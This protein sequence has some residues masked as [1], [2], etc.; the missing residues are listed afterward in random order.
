[1]SHT[2]LSVDGLSHAYAERRVITDI[3]FTAKLGDRIGLIGENGTGKSTLLRIL[4]GEQ[5]PDAGDVTLPGTVGLLRQE[6]PHPG[7]ATIADVLDDAQREQL[8]VL[9]RIERL[10]AEIARDPADEHAAD[11]YT[12]ALDTADR[13]GAWAAAARR[14]EVMSGLSLGRIAQAR[15]V[16]ELSGGQRLRLALAAL[17]IRA[18]RTLLLDEPSNHLDDDASA[19]LEGVLRG[20]NGIVIF[21]SHDRALLDGVA[22]RIL[23]LDALPVPARLLPD[24][25]SAKALEEGAWSPGA[26]D[27]TGSGYGVRLWGVGYSDARVTARR[28][29][30]ARVRLAALDRERVRKP[31]ELLDFAG[32]DAAEGAPEESATV[33]NARAVGIAGRLRETSLSVPASGKLLLSGPNGAGKSTLLSALAGTLRA[34][35]GEIERSASIGYVPQEVSFANPAQTAA[36]AYRDAV[37]FDLAEERPLTATGLLAA[38]D[39]ERRIGDLSVGQRRRVAL[40]MLVADTPPL[41]LLDEPSNHLSLTLIE[42][43]E[44]ALEQF[45][46]AVVLATHD[47]WFRERWQHPT[48]VLEPPGFSAGQ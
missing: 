1:M 34:D 14:G 22:T 16:G 31:P 47:R 25:T 10:G 21:A 11:E 27:D 48:L 8:T 30:N 26:T 36:A 7:S 6:L 15:P 23:D 46:G 43:L 41:L 3:S 35:T 12:R 17:L 18:P 45:P 44:E 32:F 24:F 39:V 33:L 5:Q 19:Y 37:G 40:A 20:W 28:A 42:E 2:H 13:T 9:E 29:R 4:A 38:R